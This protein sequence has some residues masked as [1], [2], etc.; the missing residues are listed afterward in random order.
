[1]HGNYSF[2]F[3]LYNNQK[4]SMCPSVEIC[5][6]KLKTFSSWNVIQQLNDDLKDCEVI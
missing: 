5:L 2:W 6:C 4:C 1:M 3:Y